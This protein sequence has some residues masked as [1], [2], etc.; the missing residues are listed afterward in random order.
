MGLDRKRGL[1]AATSALVGISAGALI[2]PA[3]AWIGLAIAGLL[4][5]WIAFD[6]VRMWQG[7]GRPDARDVKR[8]ADQL[9]SACVTVIL[10]RDAV[11]ASARAEPPEVLASFS[12]PPDF[13]GRFA[14]LTVPEA[15]SAFV[16]LHEKGLIQAVGFDAEDNV[17]I[18]D[19]TPLGRAVLDHLR[20]SVPLA[21]GERHSSVNV[22]AAM[23]AFHFVGFEPDVG[24]SASERTHAFAPRLSFQN[25][26]S[27]PIQYEMDSLQVSFDAGGAVVVS[28]HGGIVPPGHGTV[29]TTTEPFSI[30]EIPV[31][32]ISGEVRFV[33]RFWR[34]GSTHVYVME[35]S[36]AFRIHHLIDG[37]PGVLAHR[38]VTTEERV[39][40]WSPDTSDRQSESRTPSTL[41]E[42]NR[43]ESA[44]APPLV[45]EEVI[46]ATEDFPG[47]GT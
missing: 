15:R 14:S 47:D 18:Y 4:A 31:G 25:T 17:N 24:Q 19:W 44:L 28:G 21:A 3:L 16:R 11:E 41:P 1:G 35:R 23:Y 7:K 8:V 33:A 9:D 2:T 6:H 12:P 10:Q 42:A 32:G 29:F 45:H 22:D 30:G 46:S 26:E 13:P 37:P 38:W 5:I 27:F 34:V 20:R 39:T 36:F 43:T 40:E